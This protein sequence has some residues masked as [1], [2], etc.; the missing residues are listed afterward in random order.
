MFTSFIIDP[1]CFDFAH[2]A[3]GERNYIAAD[4][5]DLVNAWRKYGTLCL[6]GN[7][8]NNSI[9]VSAIRSV[10][11]QELKDRLLRLL[12]SVVYVRMCGGNWAANFSPTNLESFCKFSDIIVL[13]NKAAECFGFSDRDMVRTIDGTANKKFCRLRKAR[14]VLESRFEE[15]RDSHIE[16]GE[17]RGVMWEAR[18]H[19]LAAVSGPK[20]AV[21]DRFCLKRHTEDFDCS[22][23]SGL[24]NFLA[25]LD[26][27]LQ[28][29]KEVHLYCEWPED[30]R[31]LEV[32]KSKIV[33]LMKKLSTKNFSMIKLILAGKRVFSTLAHDRFI[34]FD[35]CVWDIG[36]GLDIF[37]NEI[38]EKFTAMS[39]KSPAPDSYSRVLSNLE[40]KARETKSSALCPAP[41]NI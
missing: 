10:R 7:Y 4:L 27:S 39:F 16:I 32:Q 20:I 8:P 26:K 18:F 3:P 29:P 22:P 30:A 19:P 9:T 21:V 31:I 25:L 36:S 28:S 40:Q 11:N 35:R 5:D 33:E 12:S 15:L 17:E 6:D 13:G 1:Q 38:C 23:E 41:P 2:S 24:G 37:E 14:D 34:K